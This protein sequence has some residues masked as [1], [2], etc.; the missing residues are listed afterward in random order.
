MA[1]QI[2]RR[3]KFIEAFVLLP[4]RW[5]GEQCFGAGRF[6]RR[7]LLD[8]EKLPQVCDATIR[9]GS[10]MHFIHQLAA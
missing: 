8:H 1:V 7:L 4:K 10:I 3:P 5:L 9:L 6:C 2:V